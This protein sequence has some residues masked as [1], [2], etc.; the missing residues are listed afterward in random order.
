M[1]QHHGYLCSGR[2]DTHNSIKNTEEENFDDKTNGQRCAQSGGGL[3]L[4]AYERS[5]AEE[6]NAVLTQHPEIRVIWDS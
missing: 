2:F 5:T 4:G 3:R 6:H 1:A